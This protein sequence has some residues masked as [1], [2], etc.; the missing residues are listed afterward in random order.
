M[1]KIIAS[2]IMVPLMCLSIYAQSDFNLN[3]ISVSNSTW[4]GP[5]VASGM[6][7]DYS[8]DDH[9]AIFVSGQDPTTSPAMSTCRSKW[10]SG[11]K[12]LHQCDYSPYKPT[13]IHA[14]TL[15]KPPENSSR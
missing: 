7:L 14:Y 1:E 15:S 13:A 3:S 8:A 2:V 12:M 4:L 9:S 5:V 11:P 10:G 6:K